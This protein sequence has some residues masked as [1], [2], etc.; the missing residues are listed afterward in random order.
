VA[1]P[2]A[3]SLARS[4]HAH[5]LRGDLNSSW[6]ARPTELTDRRRELALRVEN[7]GGQVLATQLARLGRGNFPAPITLRRF[8]TCE[9]W[10]REGTNESGAFNAINI[11]SNSDLSGIVGQSTAL[12]RVLHMAAM[13]AISDTTVLLLGETGTGKEL[14]ARAIHGRSQ[15]G[16][17]PS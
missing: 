17:R 16:R 15:R 6:A 9:S 3:P 12:R 11:G 10:I 5:A 2:E 8:A 14:I 13:V 7:P 1:N 4:K